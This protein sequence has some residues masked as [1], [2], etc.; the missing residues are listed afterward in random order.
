[1]VLTHNYY[2]SY[3]TRTALSDTYNYISVM[4]KTYERSKY[5]GGGVNVGGRGVHE[6]RGAVGECR[7]GGGAVG[8]CRWGGG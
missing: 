8:E 3:C 5:W 4:N 6:C 1:M 2:Y 7:G